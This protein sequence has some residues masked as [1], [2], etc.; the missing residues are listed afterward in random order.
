VPHLTAAN[1]SS[2]ARKLLKDE[3]D[4]VGRLAEPFDV[5][6]SMANEEK[7]QLT[8]VEAMAGVLITAAVTFAAPRDTDVGSSKA[9]LTL[10]V[11]K[12]GVVTATCSCSLPQRMLLPSGHLLRLLSDAASASMSVG[13]L[14]RRIPPQSCVIPRRFGRQPRPRRH[15]RPRWPAMGAPRP[16]S[17][18]AAVPTGCPPTS[19]SS[20]SEAPPACTPTRRQTARGVPKTR[21]QERGRASSGTEHSVAAFSVT[22]RYCST[23]LSHRTR[24]RPKSATAASSGR[25]GVSQSSR[26]MGQLAL[27]WAQSCPAFCPSLWPTFSPCRRMH[28]GALTLEYEC[29]ST[30]PR[31]RRYLMPSTRTPLLC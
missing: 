16:V 6:C 24:R 9:E 28:T 26:R 30:A 21:N 14:H 25:A 27:V 5:I 4:V 3:S 11:D 15:L 2:Y 22:S 13:H 1:V 31:Y 10:V 23:I 19:S 12:G 7:E 8:S 29:C 17:A 18:A 20:Q